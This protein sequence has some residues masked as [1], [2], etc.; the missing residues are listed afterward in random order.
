[1]TRE[2]IWGDWLRDYV[3]A[4]A[5]NHQMQVKRA[6]TPGE[7]D[8]VTTK[9]KSGDPLSTNLQ[10]VCAKCNNEWLSQIQERAKPI[11]IPLI[12][13]AS[14]ELSEADQA[15]IASWCA[16]ATMTAEFIDPEPLSK[17]ISGAERRLFMKDQKPPAGFRIWIGH[18]RRTDWEPQWVHVNA[19]IIG[20]E[21][22]TRVEGQE[23]QSNTRATT[24]VIGE[25]LVHVMSSA[26]YPALV[27]KWDFRGNKDLA[28]RL[29][30]IWPL[31]M[32]E[33][34][35]PTPTL[36]DRDADTIPS[37]LDRLIAES[38]QSISSNI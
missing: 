34:H 35:C 18:F 16:M 38:A 22:T 15:T 9:L 21:D 36:S 5:L 8:Q 2:H 23:A 13:G 28:S 25:L 6:I 31:D 33:I 11:L 26:G 37:V 14:I 27:E 19:P 7:P 32:R 10:I 1:M 17:G 12:Q 4:K 29:V 20:P 3:A 24:F 30:Q